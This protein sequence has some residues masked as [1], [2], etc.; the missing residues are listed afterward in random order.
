MFSLLPIGPRTLGWPCSWF[1]I[2]RSIYK[3]KLY[4]QAQKTK[5]VTFLLVI[6]QQQAPILSSL[7]NNHP[8]SRGFFK[9]E[10][11]IIKPTWFCHD[12]EKSVNF[13]IKLEKHLKIET[14]TKAVVRKPHIKKP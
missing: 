12:R 5:T 13:Y 4:C 7:N 9:K 8:P 11:Y 6:H 2:G 1:F 14:Q 3:N 10:A